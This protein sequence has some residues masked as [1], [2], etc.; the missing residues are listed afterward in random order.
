MRLRDAALL[1]QRSFWL[2]VLAAGLVQVVGRFTPLA[3]LWLWTWLPFGAWL[4]LCLGWALFAPASA[5]RV[6]R[7]V[8]GEQ[9]LKERL[10]TAL[11]L[12]TSPRYGQTAESEALVQLQQADAL[13]AARELTPHKTFTFHWQRRPLIAAGMLLVAFVLMAFLPNPMDR[14]VQERAAVQAELQAQSRR[15]EAL[16]EELQQEETLTPEERAALTRQLEELARQLQENPGD[17]EEALADIARLEAG[18]RERIN[19]DLDRQAAA[20]ESLAAQLQALAQAQTNEQSENSSLDQALQQLAE[21]LD[22]MDS[23]EQQAAAQSLADLAAQAAQ[24]G[25]PTLAQALSAMAQSALSGDALSASQAAQQAAQAMDQAQQSVSAQE[26]LSQALDQLERSRQQVAQAGQGQQVAQNPSSGQN[27]SQGQSGSQGQNQGQNPGQSGGQGQQPGSQGQNPGSG[28]GTRANT[29]PPF[30]GQGQAGRPQ[31]PGQQAAAGQLDDQVYVPFE[32]V[33]PNGD[34]VFIP[35]QDTGQG[36]SQVREGQ[37]PLP[38]ADTPVLV[39]YQQVYGEYLQAAN[40]IVD[41]GAIP[42]ALRDY[43]KSYFT[44]LEP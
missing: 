16:A 29:L 39:P 32:R 15:I 7:Q 2:A 37:N 11:A 36:D 27:G 13:A 31:G 6:A 19:P 1:A 21:Q 24:A 22:E 42:P 35:G 41:S 26:A 38:G 40:Q 10:S 28:G 12:E 14:L 18:L 23:A 25:E 9:A 44:Q 8:D 4:L 20:L 34:Q 30:Q 17:R 43:I 33:G 3:N 5:M